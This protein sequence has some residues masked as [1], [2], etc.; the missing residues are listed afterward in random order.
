ME[1]TLVELSE[2]LKQQS[3]YQLL[4]WLGITA[5]DIVDR[6][7]DFIEDGYDYLLSEIEDFDYYANE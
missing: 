4:E 2:K 5:E 1:V 6:F 7:P 3:E